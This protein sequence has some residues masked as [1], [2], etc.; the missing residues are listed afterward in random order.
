[1]RRILGFLGSGTIHIIILP[2]IAFF[3]MP[4]VILTSHAHEGAGHW[5]ANMVFYLAWVLI[6][7]RFCFVYTNRQ[8]AKENPVDE[9]DVSFY[10]VLL[11]LI[12]LS[13]CSIVLVS[14][15]IPGKN[16]PSPDVVWSKIVGYIQLLANFIYA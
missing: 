12:N 6:G 16:L 4:F 8:F 5:F 11:G 3:P 2:V 1:M 14:L 15:F 10:Q 9:N 13:L 7:V